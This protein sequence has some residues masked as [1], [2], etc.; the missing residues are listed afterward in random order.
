MRHDAATV[1]AYL[2]KLDPGNDR[3]WTSQGYP[4]MDALIAMGLTIDRSELNA[5]VP[6]FCRAGLTKDA[7]APAAEGEVAAERPS[8]TPAPGTTGD[9]TFDH[10]LER[11]ARRQAALAYLHEGGFTLADLQDN[12]SPLQRR[13][14]AQNRAERRGLAVS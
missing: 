9:S 10:M 1:R 12:V 8:P 13:I 3:H 7:P 11:A 5:L 14:A 2:G 4:R 6:G